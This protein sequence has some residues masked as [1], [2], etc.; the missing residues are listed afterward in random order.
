MPTDTV[1]GLPFLVEIDKQN[2]VAI[3]EAYIDD[4]PGFYI[5]VADSKVEGRQM[6]TTKLSPLPGENED[7]VKAAFL[8][9]W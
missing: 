5:G 7:G 3:T 8:R 2:Y 4:Y 6:L 1:A 9:R